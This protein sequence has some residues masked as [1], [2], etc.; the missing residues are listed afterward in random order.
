MISEEE[1]VGHAYRPV[2]ETIEGELVGAGFVQADA[3]EGFLAWR[4]A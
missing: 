1:I 3:P 2:W 4:L